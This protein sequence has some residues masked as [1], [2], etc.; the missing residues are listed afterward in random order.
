MNLIGIEIYESFSLINFQKT[1]K[2]YKNY[3]IIKES[4]KKLKIGDK[5]EKNNS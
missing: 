2:F 4:T 1:T 3:G 5:V